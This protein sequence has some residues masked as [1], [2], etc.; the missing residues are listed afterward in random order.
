MVGGDHRLSG[1]IDFLDPILFAQHVVAES[2]RCWCRGR[3]H[4]LAEDR[5]NPTV[6]VTGRIKGNAA[7]AAEDGTA[8]N[9]GELCECAR[10]TLYAMGIV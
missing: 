8:S 10:C 2:S 4:R 6:E 3:A 7:V 5:T 9:D 1:V